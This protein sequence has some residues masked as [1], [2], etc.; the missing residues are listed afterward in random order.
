[1]SKVMIIHPETLELREVSP[2][3]ASKAKEEFGYLQVG[4]DTQLVAMFNPSANKHVNVPES[5]VNSYEQNG[6]FANP[7]WVYH[8]EQEMQLVPA[9]QAKKMIGKDG[10][11]ESPADFSKQSKEAIVEAAVKASKAK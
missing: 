5:R 1:M 10:W 3:D 7:T 4:V 9:E 6:Y 2:N 8:P 11:C